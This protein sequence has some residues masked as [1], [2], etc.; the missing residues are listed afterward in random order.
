MSLAV[1]MRLLGGFALEA[2]GVP[3]PITSPRMQALLAYLA[4]HRNEPQPR[5]RLAFLLWAESSDA[6]AQTNLRTLLHRLHATLGSTVQ[7]IH[8]DAQTVAWQPAVTMS[9]DVDD[10]EE[11]VQQ[12]NFGLLAGDKAATITALEHAAACYAGDLLPD[13]YDEWV[14]P[15]RERLRELLITTI[16]QLVMLLEQRRA[17]AAAITHMRRLVQLDPLNEAQYLTLMRLHAENGDRAGALRVYHACASMLQ[18]EFGASPGAALVAAYERL[19]AAELPDTAPTNPMSSA[20]L[21][22]RH[23]TWR[24]MTAIWQ[25]VSAGQARLLI[26]SGEAGI[27]KTRLADELL[28]WA[29]RQGTATAVARCYAAEGE[30]AYAPVTTWLRADALRSGLHASRCGMAV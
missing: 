29:G 19:L 30:L 8:V 14:L 2:Q 28:R 27:G 4:L 24:R 9:L 16:T 3:V 21:V 11:V 10:F 20:P 1:Q 18:T 15:E 7:L 25:T 23:G 22:G 6:Q 12:A 26:L 17:Y 5:R 13:C